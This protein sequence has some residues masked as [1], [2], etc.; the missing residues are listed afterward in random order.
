MLTKASAA[1]TLF[2]CLS[3]LTFARAA[4]LRG[5]VG[6]GLITAG[7]KHDIEIASQVEFD[8]QKFRLVMN[9]SAVTLALSPPG[10]RDRLEWRSGPL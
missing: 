8:Q 6:S 5:A 3:R 1:L 9:G 4:K 7:G 10:A 2:D